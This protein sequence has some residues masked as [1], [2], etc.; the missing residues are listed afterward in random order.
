MLNGDPTPVQFANVDAE[1][2][3]ADTVFGFPLT[4]DWRLDGT[5]S[6]V[7]GKLRESFQSQR[8]EDGTART[9]QDDNIYRMPPL[10]GLLSVSRT[11]DDWVVS[12]EVDWAARQSKIS[13]LMLDDPQSGNNHNRPTSGYALYNLRTQYM[14]PSMGFML[15]AGVENLTDRMHVDH[16]NGFNRVSGGELA[17]GERLPGPGRNIYARLNWEW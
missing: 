7:R 8:R 6:Y 11:L 14:H 2:Y 13:Q 12:M 1:F 17:V 3:G 9:I 15:S 16:M 5:V 4:E 10:R